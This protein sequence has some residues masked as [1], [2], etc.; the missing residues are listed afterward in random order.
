MSVTSKLAGYFGLSRDLNKVSGQNREET[1]EGVVSDLVPELELSMTDDELIELTTQWKRK[2]DN[3]PKKAKLEKKQQENEKYWLGKQFMEGEGS[4]GTRPLVDNL[5]FEALE[6]ALPVATKQNPEPSVAAD[7]TE[8]GRQLAETVQKML[9]YLADKLTL[10]LK[11]KKSTRYWA[12]YLLGVIKI[13]YSKK[14]D[15]IELSVL[16]PQKLVLDPDASIDETGEYHGEY[17]G[18]YMEKTASKLK[19]LYPKKAAFIDLQTDKQGGT[20]LRYIQWSTDDYVCWE[21]DGE[22]LNK[23]KNPNFNYVD[24]TTEKT[25]ETGQKTQVVTKARNHFKSPKKPYIFLS[26]FNLGKQPFDET[27]LIE[28]N[29]AMQDLINKRI[30]Q[31][32]KNV[33][34]MNGGMV[35]SL[36]NFTT[37]QAKQAS[38]ALRKGGAIGVPG[39]VNRAFKQVQGVPVPSQMFDQLN[40]S[41]NELKNIFGTRGFGAGGL[42]GQK[43]VRGM[44][45]LSQADSVRIGGEISDNLEQFVDHIFNWML[46]MIYVYW[47]EPHEGSVVGQAKAFEYVSLQNSQIDR[48]LTVSVKEGSLI[49]KDEMSQA[50]QAE[51]LATAG[52]LDPI[53]LYSYLDYPNPKEMAQNLFLWK[54]NPMALF[55]EL[56]QKMQQQGQGQPSQGG[57]PPQGGPPQSG[58]P[59]QAPQGNAGGEPPLPPSQSAPPMPSINQMTGSM[60]RI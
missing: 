37:E 11:I 35:F 17:I 4:S 46:Q 56:A 16:R 5:I 25:D 39:D 30:R 8:E 57:P 3:S 31:I 59:Q 19:K 48:K 20:N 2:W 58:P 18:E 27:S 9:I 15:E 34:N 23:A 53:S 13:S 41:R 10:K 28:Q 55:P 51:T 45:M 24:T 7:N 22:I 54:T 26:I 60:P 50:K 42:A 43:T 47:D 38:T 36:D 49:P 32:D 1:S 29:L 40:D 33:D 21:M 6:S 44:A 14:E 12:L 52:M